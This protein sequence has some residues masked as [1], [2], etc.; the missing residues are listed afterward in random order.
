MKLEPKIR[1]ALRVM[2]LQRLS[3]MCPSSLL[4]EGCALGENSHTHATCMR[5]EIYVLFSQTSLLAYLQYWV[6]CLT[7]ILVSSF[8]I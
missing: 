7:L 5:I 2:L 3:Q 4:Y 6:R 1:N 8:H